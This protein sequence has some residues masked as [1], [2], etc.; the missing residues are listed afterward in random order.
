MTRTGQA[1]ID[2]ARAQTSMAQSGMCL[3]FTRECF[4]VPALYGSAVDA[5]YA[6][7]AKHPGDWSPPPATPVW[8]RS[9]SIYD[10]VCFYVSASE[11][12]STYNAD[13]RTYSSLRDVEVKFDAQ[14]VG[15]GEDINEVHILGAATPDP[16]PPLDQE[17]TMLGLARL[18]GSPDVYVGDGIT[19]RWVQ[20]QDELNDLQYKIRTGYFKGNADVIVVASIDWLGKPV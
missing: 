14:Y 20:S 17:D 1:A 4:A 18:D 15:W 16:P 13:V 3:Q 9:P 2:Y 10:H 8:F 19:R 5:G 11:V 12:I 6:C 7:N